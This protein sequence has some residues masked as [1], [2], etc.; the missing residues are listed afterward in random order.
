MAWYKDLR[1]WIA[2]LREQA[3]LTDSAFVVKLSR[4]PD[5]AVL[6]YPRVG[7]APTPSLTLRALDADSDDTDAPEPQPSG[8]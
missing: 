8:R 4:V 6:P 1:R 7:D 3:A 5:D 2:K